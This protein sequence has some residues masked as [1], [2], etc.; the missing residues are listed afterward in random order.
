MMRNDRAR[1]A[2]RTVWLLMAAAFGFAV[3]AFPGPLQRFVADLDQDW[4]VP[5]FSGAFVMF[6][7]GIAIAAAA[8]ALQSAIRYMRSPAQPVVP[9]HSQMLLFDLKLPVRLG[10]GW[11]DMQSYQ[12]L[13]DA[14]DLIILIEREIEEIER[15]EELSEADRAVSVLRNTV[16]GLRLIERAAEERQPLGSSVGLLPRSVRRA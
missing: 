11:D 15:R 8:L 16:E 2:A 5:L 13:R 4:S 10:S 3:L 6:W 14:K 12:A 7:A 9:A 1:L